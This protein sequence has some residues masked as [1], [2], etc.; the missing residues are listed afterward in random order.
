MSNLKMSVVS[1]DFD[2]PGCFENES[3]MARL[4]SEA[5]SPLLCHP[6][7]YAGDPENGSITSN[8]A[9]HVSASPFSDGQLGDTS[10]P[11]SRWT[12][13]WC[14]G[15]DLKMAGVDTIYF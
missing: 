6:P 2:V 9:D 3:V 5:N 4:A 1:L 12:P 15:L 10:F 14:K 13:L 11:W 7:L 8:I